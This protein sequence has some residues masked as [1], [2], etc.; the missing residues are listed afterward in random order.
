MIIAI[1]GPAASGKSTV[2]KLVARRLAYL[3][4]DSGAMYRAVTF[5]WLRRIKTKSTDDFIKLEDLLSTMDIRFE[6]NGKKIYLNYEDVSDAIRANEVSKNVSYIASFK[7]V[8]DKLTNIQRSMAS[9]QNVIMDGRDIGTVVFPHAEIKIFMTASAEVRAKRRLKDLQDKGENI[10]LDS[11]IKEIETRDKLD[12]ER[13]ISP[14]CKAP[15]AI[16]INTDNLSI[17]E[18]VEIICNYNSNSKPIS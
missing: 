12:S 10:D 9:G 4:I 13:A 3:Y 18:V 14:L 11:L 17:E 15:D 2:A 8:R 1:D 7:N 6:E 5:E 16:E